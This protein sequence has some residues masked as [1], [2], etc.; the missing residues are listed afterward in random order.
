MHDKYNLS[1]QMQHFVAHCESFFPEDVIK[2]GLEAQRYAY[3]AMTASLAREQ[4]ASL[5]I[6]DQVISGV[7]VRSYVPKNETQA[8]SKDSASTTT[9]LYAHGGGWYLGGLNSHDSFC[10]DIAKK[11][12]VNVISVDYRLA[13]EYPFPAGLNDCYSVYQALI[14][15][16]ITPLLM[17]D[18]AGANLMAALTL[19]CQANK[20]AQAS[21]QI[22]IYP[23]LALPLSLPSHQSLADAPLLSSDS[24]GFCFQSYIPHCFDYA[25]LATL[26]PLQAQSFKE[27]PAAAIFAAQYDPLIDDAQHYTQR[28]L[29]YGVEAECIVIKGLVHGTL[30]AIGVTDEADSLLQ[31]ICEQVLRFKNM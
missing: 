23:A 3:N 1:P 13:P 12:Q 10:A 18:S 31:S 20:L 19:R 24:I 21:A 29:Q 17:G 4:P 5:L 30:H 7:K 27:L 22:L 25:Q 14:Q 9:I 26:F 8:K 16:G 28:L 6:T 2:Q 15:Q 11:C